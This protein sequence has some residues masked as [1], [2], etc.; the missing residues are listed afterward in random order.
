MRKKKQVLFFALTQK[1]CRIRV[2][3]FTLAGSGLEAASVHTH[4]VLLRS[5]CLDKMIFRFPVLPRI[6]QY[7]ALCTK[8]YQVALQE[9]GAS[10]V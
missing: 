6:H 3:W 10:V 9:N 4:T 2:V 1:P 5:V 8:E 7:S